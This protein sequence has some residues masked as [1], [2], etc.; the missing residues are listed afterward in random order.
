MKQRNLKKK[1]GSLL[2]AVAMIVTS[3]PAFSHEVYAAELPDSTQFATVEQ[4]KSF[5]TNDQ[6][7][8]KNS[9]KVYFGQ[10]NQQWWIAGS[11]NGNVTLFAASPLATFQQFE[12]NRNQVKQY[13]ANWN[14]D[15][16]STGGSNPSNVFSNHYGASPLRTT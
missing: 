5:N 8:A 2:L 4:L 11:Q 7:G 13:N 14:C 16:T 3:F 12:K 1:V 10:N 9:A 6:D 15:Y